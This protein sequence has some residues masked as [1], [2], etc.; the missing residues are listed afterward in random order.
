MILSKINALKTRFH[1]AKI[2][3]SIK[4]YQFHLKVF[5]VR[6][7]FK[8]FERHFVKNENVKFLIFVQAY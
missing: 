8:T 3:G 7:F 4:N 5:S 1:F 2:I 6:F